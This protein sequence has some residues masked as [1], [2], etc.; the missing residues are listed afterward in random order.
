MKKK[1]PRARIKQLE[2]WIEEEGKHTNTCTYYILGRVCSNCR[3]WR[4]VG[5]AL[6]NLKPHGATRDCL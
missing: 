3:C 4:A 1:S 6:K 2:E 5:D